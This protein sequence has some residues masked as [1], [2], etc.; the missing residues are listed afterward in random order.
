MHAL[1]VICV[2]QSILLIIAGIA[3]AYDIHLNH[4]EK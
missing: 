4:K 2:C 1:I 3:I